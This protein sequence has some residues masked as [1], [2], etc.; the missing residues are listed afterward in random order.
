MLVFPLSFL[1]LCLGFIMILLGRERRA[2]H[3]VIAGT[4][5]VYGWDARAARAAVP[6]QALHARRLTPARGG[7]PAGRAAAA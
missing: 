2:L 4:A 6:G 3:D 5:V 1:V 7:A